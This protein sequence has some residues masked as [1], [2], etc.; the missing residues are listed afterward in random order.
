MC[1]L[2]RKQEKKTWKGHGN[3]IECKDNKMCTVIEVKAKGC[4][5]AEEEAT[6]CFGDQLPLWSQRAIFFNKD[7]E[8]SEMEERENYCRWRKWHHPKAQK[9][10]K[11]ELFFSGTLHL[12]LND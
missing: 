2:I 3:E 5:R 10:K 11:V 8:F 12:S 9:V 7:E 4:G 1:L 6:Y